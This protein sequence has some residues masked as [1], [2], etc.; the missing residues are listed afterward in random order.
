MA[1]NV[2][3]LCNLQ[4]SLKNSLFPGPAEQF[5]IC[6]GRSTSFGVYFFFVE[7]G[8]AGCCGVVDFKNG[9]PGVDSILFNTITTHHHIESF[10]IV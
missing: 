1:T 10:L 7:V 9:L 8:G 2:F 5:S 4:Y 6:G 3:C